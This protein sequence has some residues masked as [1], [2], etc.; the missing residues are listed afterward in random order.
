[1]T[2]AEPVETDDA[3]GDNWD[4]YTVQ[5]NDTV[6][7][8]PCSI[9]EL[10]AAGVEMD[11]EYTPEDYIVNA[12][13][14]ELAWFEDASGDSIMVDMINTGAGPAEIKDCQV[15]SISIDCEDR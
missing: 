2:P 11:R 5:I 8:L 7:T 13:E 3:L 10:E 1:M 4:S 9:A 6:V 14:Y 15:E 12:G